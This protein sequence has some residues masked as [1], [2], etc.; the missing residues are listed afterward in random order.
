[1]N[2]QAYA[3]ISSR[4]E[5]ARHRTQ[6]VLCFVGGTQNNHKTIVCV[7]KTAI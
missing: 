3:E 4:C 6:W 5:V 1:M 2:E 7:N